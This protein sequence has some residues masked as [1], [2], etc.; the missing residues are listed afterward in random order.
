MTRTTIFQLLLLLFTA[1]FIMAQLAQAQQTLRK[2]GDRVM[3]ASSFCPEGAWPAEGQTY[4]TSLNAALTAKFWNDTHRVEWFSLPDLRGGPLTQCIVFNN[5]AEN[6]RYLGEVFES[7]GN[8]L[9]GSVAADGKSLKIEGAFD[10][11]GLIATTYG[12]D[13]VK[14]FKLPN[15]NDVGPFYCISVNGPY[16]KK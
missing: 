9:T 15:L 13:G 11:Y 7:D 2:V 4:P 1:V 14:D 6:Q 10:L 16:P 12:G 3:M 8:C 5:E